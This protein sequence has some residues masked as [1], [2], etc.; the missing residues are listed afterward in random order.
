MKSLIAALFLPAVALAAVPQTPRSTEVQ[1]DMPGLQVA[2]VSDSTYSTGA[3]LFFFP[4]GGWASFDARGGSVAVAETTLLEDGS[5]SNWIDGVAFAGGSTLGLSVSDGVR[6]ALFD[7]R[8]NA[9][10]TSLFDIIP[11]I[12]SAVVY[13]FGGR[14]EPGRDPLVVPTPDMGVKLLG[15]LSDKFLVGRAGA[16]TSTTFGK[17]G[18][19]RWGGQGMAMNTYPNGV[20]VFAAVILNAMGDVFTDD[21]K[22]YRDLLAPDQYLNNVPSGGK[23]NTTLSIVVVNVDLDRSE[24]K[25]LAMQTHSS[26]GQRIRPIA[27]LDDG[28]ILF[29]VTTKKGPAKDKLKG[30]DIYAAA[31]ATLQ[32]AI[33]NGVKASNLAK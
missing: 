26:L 10:N 11:S 32:E 17:K 31:A 5:Y 20:K 6:S 21:G 16:G 28:D 33:D 4:D 7:Q 3:T 24:L 9:K 25:R 12:P 29:S 22:N 27:T 23:Q 14:K 1:F 13:D 8:K 18:G 30:F 2:S 15:N 19:P